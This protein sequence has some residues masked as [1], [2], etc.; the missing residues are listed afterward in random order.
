MV[1][2]KLRDA[3]K[4]VKRYFKEEL[5][6][7]SA[8]QLTQCIEQSEMPYRIFTEVTCNFATATLPFTK[9]IR[10]D[11]ESRT[12]L[13]ELDDMNQRDFKSQ[14]C[15][16]FDQRALEYCTTHLHTTLQSTVDYKTVTIERAV[17]GSSVTRTIVLYEELVAFP[18]WKGYRV[19]HTDYSLNY[20]D[21]DT[22]DDDD[23]DDSQERR[24]NYQ[25]S[26]DLP[27][28]DKMKHF[29]RQATYTP[30]SDPDRAALN[31]ELREEDFIA[32]DYPDSDNEDNNSQA[33]TVLTHISGDTEV[34]EE[35]PMQDVG[36]NNQFIDGE[37][38]D[39]NEEPASMEDSTC[40]TCASTY[41]R[42]LP[43]ENCWC[44]GIVEVGSC[45]RCG[46]E[47]DGQSQ[48]CSRCVRRH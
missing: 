38:M 25:I 21:S 27:F 40:L 48:W 39:D 29:K 31:R 30:Y 9:Q 7:I 4:V 2:V 20:S 33:T 6:D 19:L 11:T 1:M 26:E 37:A 15:I 22:E 43:A 10:E 5:G 44:T 17:K 45:E 8:I 24:G 36:N 16:A 41:N 3:V 13:M 32:E 14:K 35:D 42:F 28:D 34:M 23:P 18:G 12:V 46:I 47:T